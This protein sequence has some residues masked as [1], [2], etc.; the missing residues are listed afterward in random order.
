MHGVNICGSQSDEYLI[1]SLLDAKANMF[2]IIENIH[3]CVEKKS[4]QESTL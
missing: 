3:Q 4:E 1:I 2:A